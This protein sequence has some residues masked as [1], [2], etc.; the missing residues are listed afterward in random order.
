MWSPVSHSWLDIPACHYL[1]LRDCVRTSLSPHSLPDRLLPLVVIRLTSCCLVVCS[2]L[3]LILWSVSSVHHSLGSV[4][5]TYLLTHLILYADL[6]Y[7]RLLFFETHLHTFTLG[8]LERTNSGCSASHAPAPLYT[9]LL[10]PPGISAPSYQVRYTT[11]LIPLIPPP[12][13]PIQN[14]WINPALL[15][16]S[17][18]IPCGIRTLRLLVAFPLSNLLPIVPASESKSHLSPW[19]FEVLAGLNFC[20]WP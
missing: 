20:V 7:S 13:L 9:Y 6:L 2:L 1:Q 10:S 5:A 19:H 11:F 8:T 3:V 15:F 18:S 12:Y 14:Q 16:C 17:G 4:S